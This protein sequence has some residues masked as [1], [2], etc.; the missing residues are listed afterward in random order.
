ML[1][2]L[3]MC[4]TQL[5]LAIEVKVMPDTQPQPDASYAWVGRNLPVWGNVTGGTPPYTYEWDINDDGTPEYTSPV[6]NPKHILVDHTYTTA[7]TYFAR[8]T[9]TDI[10]SAS[11]SAT[12]RIRVEPLS[13]LKTQVEAAI[14]DG[15]RHLYLIQRSDGTWRYSNSYAVGSTGM[16]VLAFEKKSYY[17][18]GGTIF[19]D[20]IAR[21]LDYLFSRSFPI[22]ISSEPLADAHHSNSEG[23]AIY[24]VSSRVSYE[25]PIAMM[26]IVATGTPGKTITT[27]AYSGRTY[28]YLIEEAADW[29]AFAQK[30]SG[31]YGG[32]WRY[33]ANYS[34]SDNSVS[35][36][37]AIGLEAA[38]TDWGIIAPPFV[39]DRLLNNW[40]PNS[41]HS[42]GKFGYTGT[43]GGGDI[44]MTAAGICELAYCDVSSLTNTRV[45]NAVNYLDTHWHYENYY[46]M[47]GLAKGCR[48][49]LPR[50]TLIGARDWQEEYNQYLVSNQSY[51][52][53]NGSRWNYGSYDLG[54]AFAVLIMTPGIT[55]PVPVADAGPD[56]DMPPGD[57]VT[58]DGTGS[59]HQD[60]NKSIVK[61]E[62]DVDNDGTYDLTGAVV[63]LVGGYPDTG[64][65]YSVTVTL[66]V[67]DEDGLENADTL[68]VNI[69]SGNVP[70]IADA[71]G[72]YFGEVGQPITFDGSGSYDPNEPPDPLNDSIVLYEWDLD[73]D[74]Q[75]DDATGVT[76][77]KTW[78]T[79]HSGS[80][81]L[82]VTDSYGLSDIASAEYTTVAVS[83]LWIIE[84]R[85]STQTSPPYQMTVNPDGTIAL[86]AYME[87]R[88]ENRGTGD[89]FNVTASLADVPG[90][91]TIVDGDVSFVD[92]PA[93]SDKWSTDDF[94]IMLMC[95][96]PT[97]DTV[98]WNI[99]WDDAG[100]H[101]H[102]MQN[103]P[104]F[105]P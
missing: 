71:G 73:G 103:V 38:E 11:D 96:G 2:I 14:Q 105:G 29:C 88:I 55:I 4:M 10:A 15:L 41:Q 59:Y 93:Q 57:D 102:L 62:W 9:V 27:G 97:D 94:C 68:R 20:T 17:Q 91:V 58:F 5:A 63:T 98:W 65:D 1:A 49:S 18:D 21:G 80:I 74:G 101:H 89:A 35:Q 70:P 82:K 44:A 92:V 34:N 19:A 16:A 56:Q 61:Y 42:S 48:I 85:W 66:R 78:H 6:S 32:G 64:A 13:T 47:Y 28:Q 95:A 83:E 69:T 24:H 81:G 67:T 87:V 36:W 43:S 25:T 50:I 40:I 77:S 39:K 31:Y 3:L 53:N 72:P 12:V 99:E 52:I 8:L 7:G 84:Y 22:S 86:K 76:A 79:P 60:P 90:Y 37:P 75:Y 100:G 23:A 26:A 104:M 33:S 30:N 51:N 46:A 45:L 54:T